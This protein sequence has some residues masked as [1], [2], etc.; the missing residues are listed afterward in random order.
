MSSFL[1]AC[2]RAMSR[3]LWAWLPARVA[4]A[5]WRRRMARLEGKVLEPRIIGD[6]E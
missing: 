6:P 3:L 4:E 5:R 1:Q 2:Q